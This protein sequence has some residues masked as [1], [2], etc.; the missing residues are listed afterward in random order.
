VESSDAPHES[1]RKGGEMDRVDWR[2]I[3]ETG[4]SRR[5]TEER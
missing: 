2:E 5:E 1:D 4:A 3:R